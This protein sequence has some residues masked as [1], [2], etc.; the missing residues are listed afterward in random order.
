V[1]LAVNAAVK[2]FSIYAGAFVLEVVVAFMS[3]PLTQIVIM[4][5]MLQGACWCRSGCVIDAICCNP[6]TLAEKSAIWPDV[7]FLHGATLKFSS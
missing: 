7:G 4:F 5:K 1:G 2:L 3:V 6:F